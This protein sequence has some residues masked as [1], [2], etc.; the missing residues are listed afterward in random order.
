MKKNREVDGIA[1]I[2][3]SLRAHHRVVQPRA[4]PC[5]LPCFVGFG[6]FPRKADAPDFRDG[7]DHDKVLER[8]QINLSRPRSHMIGNNRLLKFFSGS[9]SLKTTA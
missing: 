7:R 8:V 9:F 6:S 2:D 4:H 1:E 3:G 5:D